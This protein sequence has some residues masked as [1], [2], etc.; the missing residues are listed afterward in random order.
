VANGSTTYR[1]NQ[2]YDTTLIEP[3]RGERWVSTC[4]EAEDLGFLLAW[5]WRANAAQT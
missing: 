5:R 3:G 1:S 4:A 2:Q